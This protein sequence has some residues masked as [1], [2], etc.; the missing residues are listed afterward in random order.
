[1]DNGHQYESEL[2][3]LCKYKEKNLFVDR[4][5]INLKA[6]NQYCVHINEADRRQESAIFR[7]INQTTDSRSVCLLCEHC[8]NSDRLNFDKKNRS[9]TNIQDESNLLRV[10]K[11]NK[12]VLR[13]QKCSNIIFNRAEIFVMMKNKS[14]GNSDVDSVAMETDIIGSSCNGNSTH[15]ND[16]HVSNTR[17]MA[18][19][20][21]LDHLKG[22]SLNE[23]RMS[24]TPRITLTNVDDEGSGQREDEAM[25]TDDD[26][27]SSPLS[28]RFLTVPKIEE[29]GPERR[30]P[31][32]VKTM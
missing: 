26:N 12:R 27:C 23:R 11:D 8:S 19:E 18:N 4:Q 29:L 17:L 10:D 14:C 9:L 1:M 30:P 28:P 13:C 5:N 7:Q 3:N 25:I 15:S 21:I 22:M 24:V 2:L 31:P 32:M 6:T 16:G 20:N